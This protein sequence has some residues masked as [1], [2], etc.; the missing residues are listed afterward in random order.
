MLLSSLLARGTITLQSFRTDCRFVCDE[1]TN[2]GTNRVGFFLT[3]ARG[4]G[5]GHVT[6]QGIGI[7]LQINLVVC[8]GNGSSS[9]NR[10]DA[11]PSQDCWDSVIHGLSH[12]RTK[13]V[14]DRRNKM[15]SSSLTHREMRS[16]RTFWIQEPL[17]IHHTSF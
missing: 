14:L 16:E 9:S 15:C 10:R 6:Q 5:I 7:A 17:P 4:K 2:Q 13:D 8:L 3:S 1:G 11:W 12:Y